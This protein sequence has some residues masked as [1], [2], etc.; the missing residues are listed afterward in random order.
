M[1]KIEVELSSHRW[2]LNVAGVLPW[3]E[4]PEVVVTVVAMS[5][6][7]SAMANRNQNQILILK[8]NLILHEGGHMH[9]KS[10]IHVESNLKATLQSLLLS[11]TIVYFNLE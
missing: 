3:K 9:P 10:R 6:L 7:P 4:E 2:D 5:Y 8:K 1:L 11:V